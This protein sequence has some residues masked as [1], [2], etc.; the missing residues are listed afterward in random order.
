LQQDSL[1]H[2]W[3]LSVLHLIYL[4][5]NKNNAFQDKLKGYK[6]MQYAPSRDRQW[7]MYTVI[8]KPA[9]RRM[10]LRTLVRQPKFVDGKGD[11]TT[12]IIANSVVKSLM[13]VLEELEMHAHNANAKSDH[14]HMF[15]CILRAQELSDLITNS[16]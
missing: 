15:L 5:S 1:L 10:F 3:I 2:S 12:S 6:E 7:H 16:K 14:V 13:G 9:I 4:V 11:S 8:D